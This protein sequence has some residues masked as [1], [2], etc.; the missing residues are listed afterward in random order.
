[1]ESIF[2]TASSRDNGC[3]DGSGL[4]RSGTFLRF[5]ALCEAL[6]NG[7]FPCIVCGAGGGTRTHKSR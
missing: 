3:K 4:E 5:A 1:M 7:I 2:F 6:D